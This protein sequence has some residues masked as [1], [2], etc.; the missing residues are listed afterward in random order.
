[1]VNIK[2]KWNVL[3]VNKIIKL[4]TNATIDHSISGEYSS[5]SNSNFNEN[6]LRR[7]AII[8]W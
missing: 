1:M 3:E 7:K 6:K 8:N 5:T 2:Q 4:S